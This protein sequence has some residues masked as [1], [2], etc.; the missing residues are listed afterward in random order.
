MVCEKDA[1]EKNMQAIMPM[2]LMLLIK[3][4]LVGKEKLA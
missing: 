1:W 3:V 4:V 2:I